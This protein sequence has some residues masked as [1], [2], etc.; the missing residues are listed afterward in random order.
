MKIV[1]CHIGREHLGIQYLSSVLKN[2]GHEVK[3]AYDPGYFSVQ[4]NTIQNKY[5]ERIFSRKKELIS[6]VVRENPDIVAFAVYTE[7]FQMMLEIAEQIKKQVPSKIIFGGTHATL[8]PEKVIAH[9]VVDIVVI[10][11]GEKTLLNILNTLENNKS[12]HPINNIYFKQN[13]V[14]VRNPIKHDLVNINELPY[15]D[16]DIF[17]PYLRYSDDYLTIASRGCPYSCTFC[18]ESHFNKITNNKNYRQREVESMINELVFMKNKYKIREIIFFDNIFHFNEEWL[19]NFLPEYSKNIA[20]PFKCLGHVNTFN[21]E[22]A[23]LLKDNYCYN[24]NFG[25]QSTDHIVRQK[26]LNR[27]T[28]DSRIEKAFSH[29]ENVGLKFDIDMIFDLPGEDFNSIAENAVVFKG[30]KLLNRIKCFNLTH[31]PN[32]SIINL[33]KNAGQLNNIAIEKINEGINVLPFYMIPE[34]G[35]MKRGAGKGIIVLYKLLP[36]LPASLIKYFSR[37]ERYKYLQYFPDLTI[38][39]LQFISGLR[40]RDY[41]FHYYL[42]NYIRRIYFLLLKFLSF[43]RQ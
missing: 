23:K 22:I 36:I 31:Y 9:K 11:E 26:F 41:R 17:A 15:P 32:L 19:N 38:I 7:S 12:L 10:G 28:N 24:I 33:A 27:F 5:L 42:R 30:Y 39:L 20:V 4:D 25:L 3:L 14:V 37:N 16:K 18:S 29:C 40:N 34:D 13:D 1:F 35:K 6:T 43:T 2:A 8:V 21:F